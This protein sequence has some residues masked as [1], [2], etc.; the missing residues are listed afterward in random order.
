MA[1]RAERTDL[2]ECL[3]DLAIRQAQVDPGAEVRQGP[4]RPLGL[5][6]RDDRFDGALTDVLD[7]EEAKSDGVPF[8]GELELAGVHVGR[9]NLNPEPPTLGDCSCDLVLG[10][11]ERG[12]HT[13]HVLDRVVRLEIRGLVCNEPVA[14][15]MG[16]VE[17]V[18]LERLEGLEHGIDRLRFHAALRGLLDELLLLG[19]QDR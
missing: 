5:A 12:Q 1:E 2:G 4:E 13:G 19:P 17:P 14:G 16:L 10:T 9:S 3:E 15:G 6:S 7:R 18:A 8:D 11:P